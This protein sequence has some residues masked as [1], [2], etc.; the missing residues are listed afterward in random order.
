MGI[1]R[2]DVGVPLKKLVG[3]VKVIVSPHAS[4]VAVVN[5]KTTF[6]LVYNATRSTA[7]ICRAVAVTCPPIWG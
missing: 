5:E 7:A 2:Y 3:K 6:R 1:P 4:D